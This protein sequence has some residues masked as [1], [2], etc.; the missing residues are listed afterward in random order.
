[1]AI[2]A[3]GTLAASSSPPPILLCYEKV[4]GPRAVPCRRVEA[5]GSFQQLASG[6]GRRGVR[7]EVVG[8]P[9]SPLVPKGKAL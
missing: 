1:A 4:A 2:T 9:Q 8:S 5:R 6:A 7:K 3:H